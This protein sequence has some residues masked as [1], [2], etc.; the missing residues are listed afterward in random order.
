MKF[1]IIIMIYMSL[2]LVYVLMTP[3]FWL[4]CGQQRLNMFV[5]LIV[6]NAAPDYVT[7]NFCLIRDC[8][9]KGKHERTPSFAAFQCL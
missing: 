3:F 4:I 1:I 2:Q 9:I 6:K 7:I 5:Y 8:A